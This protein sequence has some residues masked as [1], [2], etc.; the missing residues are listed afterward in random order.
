MSQSS[1]S[2]SPELS[3]LSLNLSD[4]NAGATSSKRSNVVK[5]SNLKRKRDK[6]LSA[7]I[8]MYEVQSQML[9]NLLTGEI[10]MQK[11]ELELIELR[12]EDKFLFLNLES[13]SDLRI[14]EYLRV[15]QRKVMLKRIPHLQED[16][17]SSTKESLDKTDGDKTSFVDPKTPSTSQPK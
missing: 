12:R 7:I 3:S 10:E 5:K 11:R 6:H 2:R 15:E 1:S 14:R 17:D 16:E 9:Q 8:K 4:E 13:I